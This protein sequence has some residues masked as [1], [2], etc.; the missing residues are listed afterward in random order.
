MTLKERLEQY[1]DKGVCAMHMPGHKRRC[2]LMPEL[3]GLDITEID[4]FDNLH[5][6]TGIL[7]EAQERAARLVGADRT[8][9]LV[10]GSTCGLLAGIFAA[11]KPGETVV[12]ARNCHKAVYHGLALREAKPVYIYP[13]TTAE[14]YA[15]GISP[16]MVAQ[17]IR[18][19]GAKACIITSPTY[20][21][22]VSDVA[23]IARYCHELGAVLLVDEAHGA[24]LPFMCGERVCEC[25]ASA[26]RA[27]NTS[28]EAEEDSVLR[29]NASNESAIFFPVSALRMGADIVVQ[30]VHKTLPAP[31]QTALLHLM[32]D[33][34][35]PEAVSL[36]LGM[37]ETSSPSY[38]LMAGIDACMAWLEREG[39]VAAVRYVR[40]LEEC[41][42]HAKGWQQLRLIS[43]EGRDPGK[44]LVSAKCKMTGREI[45]DILRVRFDIQPEM[46]TEDYCLL[47]TSICDDEEVYERVRMALDVLDLE[48]TANA[49]GVDSELLQERRDTKNPTANDTTAEACPAFPRAVA[50]CSM[51]EALTAPKRRVLISELTVDEVAAE[52][53]GAYPPGIPLIAPGERVREVLPRLLQE[54]RLGNIG[55]ELWVSC[56]S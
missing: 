20:E 36:Y 27:K 21:G 43:P 50:C 56:I 35:S 48:L 26:E 47:M 28:G 15:A 8:W 44:L 41:Y 31:T 13:E 42:A 39:V 52:W 22:V 45:Y 51:M 24:H 16:E 14:G 10:N 19:S 17:A 30:S 6:A 32:G 7:R 55:E 38:P 2:E 11:V 18:E 3:Y 33:R 5:D 34:V 54:V 46:A 53:V 4:G 9:F 1:R 25:D 37:F 12:V 29:K 49:E 23:T 40:E